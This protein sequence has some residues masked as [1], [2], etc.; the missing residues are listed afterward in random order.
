MALLQTYELHLE[1]GAL[2]GKFVALTC[3]ERDLVSR[4]M[5]VL[6]ENRAAGCQVHQFARPLFSLVAPQPR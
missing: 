1:G 2:D 5:Q 3:P 6:A 4:A